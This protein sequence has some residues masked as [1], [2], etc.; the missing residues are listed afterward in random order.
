MIII[1]E[2]GKIKK[3]IFD[4]VLPI[5]L[6][7]KSKLFCIS[8]MYKDSLKGRFFERLLAAETMSEEENAQLTQDYWSQVD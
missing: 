2:A 8:T 1:D 7:E 6:A 3:S 5:V 4:G